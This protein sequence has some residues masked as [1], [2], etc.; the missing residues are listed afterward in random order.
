M[1][2]CVLESFAI[3]KAQLGIFCLQGNRRLVILRESIAL[4]FVPL[5]VTIV[6]P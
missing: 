5:N 2:V 6:F 3:F 4:L 1:C